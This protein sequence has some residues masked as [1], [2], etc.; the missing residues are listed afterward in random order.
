[1]LVLTE[2]GRKHLEKGLPEVNL[3]ALVERDSVDMKEAKGK[4][5]D[6]PI[7]LLWAKKNGWVAIEGSR[8]V[9]HGEKGDYPVP[10]ALKRVSQGKKVEK[11]LLELLIRRKLVTKEK[12]AAHRKIEGDVTN[13]TPELIQSGHWKDVR[14]KPYNV[15]AVGERVYPGK[16]QPYTRFVSKV[17]QK[18]VELGFMEMTGPLIETEFW[19]FDA[20]FQPQNH[21]ARD[22][23]STYQLKHPEFGELPRKDIVDG[24]MEAHK[25]GVAG[26]RG[27]GYRW[28][29]RR[30]TRLMPRAHG[31]CLSARTL[32][33][34]PEIPGKYFAVARCYR[35]DVLDATHL[36]EFNQVEGIV[37]DESLNLRHLLGILEIF[38]KKIAG[39][40]ELRFFPDY[41]PFTEPSVQLSAKHPEF[42]WM[43]FGGSGIFRE[44]LTKPLGIDVPVIAWGI[45]IDRLA[46]FK[47]GVEDI[48]YL[49]TQNL[50]WLRKSKAVL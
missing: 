49:F 36:I 22:W 9:K 27:W 31:T 20:L 25:G 50:K 11:D 24:V 47:L 40:E 44:E 10:M 33:A 4:V 42:G 12:K 19:N 15:A 37:I 21:P 1:M 3:L 30:A 13:L 2:E 45:G 43:E 14:L 26:S 17:K 35:P 34:K 39:A 23:T 38:A 32:A 28:D 6:F 29:P 18:L 7:A 8:I 41:Y 48:R 5:E 46:M 16:R